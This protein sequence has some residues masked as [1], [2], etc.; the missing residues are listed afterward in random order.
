MLVRCLW[1]L[2]GADSA[3]CSLR[4]TGEEG[5]ERCGKK[6]GCL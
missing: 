4:V 5:L 1:L 3:F 6:E 2:K